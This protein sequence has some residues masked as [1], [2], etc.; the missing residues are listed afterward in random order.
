M[1]RVTNGIFKNKIRQLLI[2]R[3]NLYHS[4]SKNLYVLIHRD[5][6][7]IEII[8]MSY[9]ESI[10]RYK[11]TCYVKVRYIHTIHI[12]RNKLLASIHQAKKKICLLKHKENV[13]NLESM[14]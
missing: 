8:S 7:E 1:T 5:L 4:V 10:D 9:S 13:D 2:H 14:H 11:F 12:A 3:D 6:I